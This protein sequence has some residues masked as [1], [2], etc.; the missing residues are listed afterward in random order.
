MHSLLLITSLA[1]IATASPARAQ[2][3]GTASPSDQCNLRIDTA[4]SNWIIEGFDPFA[5]DTAS[6]TFDLVFINQGETRCEIYPILELNGEGFGLRA[7][8]AGQ[9]LAYVLYDGFGGYDATPIAGR[10]VGRANRRSVVIEPGN[11]QLIRYHLKVAGNNVRGDGLYSQIISVNAETLE[12]VPVAGRQI[13]IGLDVLPSA[14]M[15]LAGAYRV[16]N[17]Q[18]VV[19]LGELQE[20]PAPIPLHLRIESTRSYRV[21]IESQN[22]GKLVMAGS[23][24]S[25]PYSMSVG[26]KDVTLNSGANEQ[27]GTPVQKGDEI[28]LPVVF[29]IGNTANQRAG[30]YGDVISIT[31]S[32]N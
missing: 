7:D 11:Q 25:I 27:S 32:P 23:D 17:G 29:N 3:V 1:A 9:P 28:S 12:G 22:N 21:S 31:V 5:N 30:K 2:F 26:G 24:W 18:A 4:A 10:T 15:G 19:D 20:G 16:R 6:D 13:V 8:G 14:R